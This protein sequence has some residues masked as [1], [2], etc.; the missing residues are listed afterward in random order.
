MYLF[1][2]ISKYYDSYFS[3]SSNVLGVVYTVCV[4]LLCTIYYDEYQLCEGELYG[5]SSIKRFVVETLVCSE[6]GG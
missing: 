6:A 1:I 3:F 2:K 4:D 5:I